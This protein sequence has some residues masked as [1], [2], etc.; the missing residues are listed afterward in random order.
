M[1]VATTDSFVSPNICKMLAEAGMSNDMPFAWKIKGIDAELV[2]SMFDKDGIYASSDALLCEL[3]LAKFVPAY[4]VGDCLALLPD[5]FCEKL[6]K[7]YSISVDKNY[8][9]NASESV[10]FSDALAGLVLQCFEKRI[11]KQKVS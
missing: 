11:I 1:N 6:N 7:N 10:R 5:F 3:R 2:S 8:G 9:L 4:T